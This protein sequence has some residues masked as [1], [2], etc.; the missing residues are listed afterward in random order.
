MKIMFSIV[1]FSFQSNCGLRIAD[2]GFKEFYQF[3]K[4]DGAKRYNKSAIRNPQSKILFGTLSLGIDKNE[5][6]EA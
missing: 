4:N 6:Y 1:L 2:C 3:Y 5:G